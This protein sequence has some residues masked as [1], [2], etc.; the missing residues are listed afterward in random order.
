VVQFLPYTRKHGASA[1][2]RQVTWVGSR[3]DGVG[4]PVLVASDERDGRL[5][6]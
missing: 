1:T 6:S 3:T 5:L 4:R 2:F